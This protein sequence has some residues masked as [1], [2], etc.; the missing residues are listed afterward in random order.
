MCIRDSAEAKA[1]YTDGLCRER[2]ITSST[3]VS[4]NLQDFQG[5]LTILVLVSAL[6]LFAARFAYWAKNRLKHEEDKIKTNLTQSQ[7]MQRATDVSAVSKA[8]GLVEASIEMTHP[9]EEAQRDAA[10]DEV[11]TVSKMKELLPEIID[12]INKA[13]RVRSRAAGARCSANGDDEGDRL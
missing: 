8:M 10:E 5:L 4:Y 11:L 3:V 9:P 12:E 2:D 1:N 7:T 6:S 13:N